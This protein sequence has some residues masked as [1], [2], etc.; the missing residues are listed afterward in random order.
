[1]VQDEKPDMD[2]QSIV[3]RIIGGKSES[4]HHKNGIVY[5]QGDAADS[6][7]F[8]ETGTVKVTVLSSEGKEAV[9]GILQPGDFFGEE[10]LSGHKLR[11]A[12]A[13]AMTECVLFRFEKASIVRALRDDAAFSYL[14]LSH[15]IARN[16]RM[17]A[18]LVDQLLNSV[19]KRLARLLLIL[20]N[21]GEEERPEAILPKVSQ[22]TLAEM[23]G[24]SRTHV[25]FFMN[26][27]RQLGFIEYNGNIKVKSS[28]LN[29]LLR[30][31]SRR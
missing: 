4:R 22:E 5:F 28:L 17:Q 12:S 6:V 15:L 27:F 10:C 16:G 26:K 3:A 21:Y 2:P 9:V 31:K 25:N 24:T 7:F 29:M 30:I 8:V 19:E 11:I 14:F 20:A 18:D 23:I 1:M 13:T